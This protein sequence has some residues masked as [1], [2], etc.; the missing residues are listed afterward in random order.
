M[1][2]PES[3]SPER[4]LVIRLGA[5][6]DV[7]LTTPLLRAM[8]K[9]F[10]ESRIDFLVKKAFEP[11]LRGNPRIA[12]VVSFDPKGGRKEW[13]RIVRILRR[14]RYDWVV[15]LQKNFRSGIFSLSSGAGRVDRYSHGRWRRFLL[16]KFRIPPPGPVIPMALRYFTAVRKFGVKDD[17]AGLEMVVADSAGQEAERKLRSLGSDLKGRTVI[18]APGAGR[19]TKRW[20]ANGYADVGRSL[21]R[22]GYRILLVGGSADQ[23]VCREVVRLM[24]DRAVSVAGC[25]SLD[26]TAA[27][28]RKTELLITNDT[29][30]MHMATA[31]DRPVVA[32]FGPTTIHL[33]FFPFRGK[34]SVIE[35]DLDCRPCSFHGTKACPK[36]H[37][38]CMKDISGDDV[39]R[40]AGS[41]I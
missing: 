38:R 20:P 27:L 37:F 12:T 40:A 31:L 39:L 36:K 34:S 41:L 7:L 15:D 5:L 4:I 9:R 17:G 32:V 3:F 29:G 25:L 28:L 16:V 14:N 13:I 8:R 22:R 21:D 18:L 10:P 33:G 26:Q 30:L 1:R 6:G 35:K 23:E 11:V 24:E 2:H 19:A